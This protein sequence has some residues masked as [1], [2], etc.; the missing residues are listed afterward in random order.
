[1]RP[2]CYRPTVL[3]VCCCCVQTLQGTL[4]SDKNELLFQRGINYAKL[5]R[6]FRKASVLLFK[7][8]PVVRA[9]MLFRW[10]VLYS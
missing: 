1:M 7:D 6:M 10:P 5:P 8:L 4:S 3:V 9:R 2:L